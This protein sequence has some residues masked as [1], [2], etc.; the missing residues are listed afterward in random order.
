MD[1][2]NPIYVEYTRDFFKDEIN[3][4]LYNIPAKELLPE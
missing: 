1:A 3:K 4:G 2:I